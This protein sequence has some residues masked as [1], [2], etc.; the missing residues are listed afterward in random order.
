MLVFTSGMSMMAVE[1]TGLRLLAPYFGTSLLVTT[2]LIGSMMTFL[3]IGYWLG[4]R[5][6]DRHPSLRRLCATT[7]TAGLFIL[8]V[9]LA[10]QPILRGASAALRPLVQGAELSN[11][12]VAMTTVV[13]GLLGTLA[14]LAVPVTLMGTVSPWAIRLAVARVEDAGSTAGRLYALSTVGSIIGS[15]LPALVLVPLLGVRKTFF[16]A[17]LSLLL[18]SVVGLLSKAGTV[19]VAAGG[20][21]LMLL[22]T[23]TVRP[24]DGL[25][26]EGESIYH[27]IQVVQEPYGACPNAYHLYLNEGIGI[28][29]VKC[30]DPTKEIRGEWTYMAAAPLWLDKM[31]SDPDVLIVGLAGGTSARQILEAFPRSNIVGVEIDKD[32]VE[33]SKRYLDDDDPRI[34]P[35]I[36]DGRVFLQNTNQRFD[37]ILM[38]AYR[39]PYIPFHLV[40]V[41]FF[42]QAYQ[43]LSDGGVL[44]VNVASVRGVS[45]SLTAM[46]YR[47]LREV[48][49][50]VIW[51]DA[52]QS[53]DVI[54]ATK[55]KT[56]RYLAANRLEHGF[57]TAAYNTI[58]RGFRART[59]GPVP[60]WEDA[61]LLTDDQAPVEAAWDL[62]T[63]Q[64]AY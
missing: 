50:T 40:T 49:D 22:P 17:G 51:V 2:V 36:M 3:S 18:V 47:T 12:T 10:S 4:G 41:E 14:L 43:H 34:K 62:M 1:M 25:V 61:R 11:F 21:A 32:V 13:G 60:G 55:H 44:A 6:G 63:L 35:V 7:A 31:R 57:H 30:P 46:I 15:F 24:M 23:G 28:H 52:T 20:A 48:F 9:P 26:Y 53:N 33:I 54:Y 8:L 29:S 42:R 59:K 19:S 58:R 16:F 38:D 56:D 27:F 39:Q 45:R 64:Y 5:V 37:V